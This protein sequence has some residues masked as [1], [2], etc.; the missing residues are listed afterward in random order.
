[1][2]LNYKKKNTIGWSIENVVLDFTGGAFSMAQLIIDT[3]ARGHSLFSGDSFNVVKFILSLMSIFFDLIF[4]FQHWVLYR[5]K[6]TDD[7]RD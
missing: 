6:V 7:K 2:Y 3:V 1:V 4:M 5:H